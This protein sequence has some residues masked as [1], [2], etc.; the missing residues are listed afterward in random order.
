MN[1]SRAIIAAVVAAG[2]LLVAFLVINN[3]SDD[4]DDADSTTSAVS[5]T[6]DADATTTSSDTSGPGACE[7]AN[8][9]LVNPGTLTI[10]TDDP[11]FPPW[12]DFEDPA[13]GVGFESAVGKAI[14][15]ELGFAD[16]QVEWIVVPFN[17]A[18]APG[19]KD[20]DF[21]INQVSIRPERAEVIDFSDGYYEVRQAL[22][23]LEGSPAI[24]A[25]TI[26]DL[27]DVLLGAQIG[28]T[29]L[30]YIESVIQ[31]NNQALVYDT[32]ADAKAALE[33]G[34]VDALVFDLDTAFFIVAVEIEDASVVGQFEDIGDSPE[35]FG[36][37]FEKDNPLV[38]CVNAALTTL[39][40]NG[41][42]AAFEQEYL[43]DATGA[44]VI[45]S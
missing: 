31:P 42:L 20:F 10:G 32:N 3:S 37:V 33:A 5:S 45:G 40:D 18:F 27:K 15:G 24:G 14:A 17:N 39:R 11:A 12:F 43:A 38:T 29:S 21:D 6:T 23:A 9:N 1:N 13:S 25:K 19:A 41:S 30:D 34:Q 35:E 7:I 2:L 28:T 8:L 16:D 26:A 22:V 36:L 44:P 4:E